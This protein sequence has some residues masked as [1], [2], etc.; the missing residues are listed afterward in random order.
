MTA[1][2]VHRGV[3][4]RGEDR[5]GIGGVCREGG[6]LW[7]GGR[8]GGIAIWGGGRRGGKHSDKGGCM[9]VTGACLHPYP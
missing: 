5:G 4:D 1:G 7:G 8:G 6:L 9:R 2:G 3:C